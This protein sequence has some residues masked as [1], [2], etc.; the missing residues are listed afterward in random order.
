[1]PTWRLTVRDGS[2]VERVRHESLDAALADLRSRVDELEPR[3]RR[4]EVKFLRRKIEPV[5]QVAARIEIAGPQRFV[6]AVQGGIDLRGD[7]SSE[8]YTGRLRRRLIDP[9]KGENTVAAL[10][11]AL[12]A[13]SSD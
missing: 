7:G 12:R 5:S 1:M 9:K 2:R 6:P 10:T 13:Q 11:R 3:A 8:A 4:D